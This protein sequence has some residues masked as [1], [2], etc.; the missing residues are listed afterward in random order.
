MAGK[1][2]LAENSELTWV[3]TEKAAV[4]Q[5]TVNGDCALNPVSA[6]EYP[7]SVAAALRR[8][9]QPDEK[10]SRWGEAWVGPRENRLA[11]AQVRAAPQCS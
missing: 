1:L 3:R 2:A 5:S 7:I 11:R 10:L 8:S 6:L 9:R 4:V